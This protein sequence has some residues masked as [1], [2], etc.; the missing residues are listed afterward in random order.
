MGPTNLVSVKV[1]E[2]ELKLFLDRPP[3][4][5]ERLDLFFSPGN[6]L[7]FDAKSGLRLYR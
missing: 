7:F 2:N 5:G 6:A 4:E 1:G 3:E